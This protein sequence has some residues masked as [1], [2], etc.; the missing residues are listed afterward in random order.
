M[1]K[2]R[3]LPRILIEGYYGG[4]FLYS[5]KNGVYEEVEITERDYELVE[6][7]S[8][9][10]YHFD[11]KKYISK[12]EKNE[13]IIYEAK[14]KEELIEKFRVPGRVVIVT[15]VDSQF[16]L[17]YC[18]NFLTSQ[19][20]TGEERIELWGQ[21]DKEKFVKLD[22]KLKEPGFHEESETFMRA[23]D[24][25]NKFYS[26]NRDANYY[27]SYLIKD[28]KII[29]PFKHSIP[30]ELKSLDHKILNSSQIGIHVGDYLN[31]FTYDKHTQKIKVGSNVYFHKLTSTLFLV[32]CDKWLKFY[33]QTSVLDKDWILIQTLPL[34]GQ[35]IDDIKII[36]PIRN[37]F[38]SLAKILPFDSL[39]FDLIVMT[40]EFCV[41]T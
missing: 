40:A 10:C 12:Q 27:L 7:R 2:L 21:K 14:E 20:F 11:D 13:S 35:T 25:K 41:A 34:T 23:E 32:Y 3:V 28:S 4:S 29:G 33:S 39:P 15:V 8:D 38:V 18:K 6:F 37:D 16:L 5:C 24:G 19:T 26:F 17:S 22:E 9:W 31:I 1:S 30:V 36:P